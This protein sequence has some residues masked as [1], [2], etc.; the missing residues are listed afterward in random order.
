MASTGA[1]NI[2]FHI[3]KYLDLARLY[4]NNMPDVSQED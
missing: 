2:E 4:I 1:V 3:S